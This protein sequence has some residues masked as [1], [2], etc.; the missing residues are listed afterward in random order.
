MAIL[1]P[2]QKLLFIMVPGT[3]CSVIGSELQRHLG[4]VW[5]P[6]KDLVENGR[7]VLRRKHNTV[8]Q[9]LRAGVL[10]EQDLQDLLIFATA[11]NPY[12]RFVTYYQRLVGGWADNYLD[13][14]ER[15]I[16]R[17]KEN[18]TEREYNVKLR[19]YARL[20]ERKERR[21]RLIKRVG[22]NT[23][24]KASLLRW[25]FADLRKSGSDVVRVEQAFPMLNRV[26]IAIRYER[27][28]DGLNEVLQLAGVSQRIDLP[29]KNATPGKRSYKEYYSASTRLVM[30][31]VLGRELEAFGYGYD[32][33]VSNENLIQLRP[34]T[35]PAALT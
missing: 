4:G 15:S 14:L 32:G 31:A 25:R 5:V 7:I 9:M 17:E 19:H 26:N 28:E 21:A 8:D 30:Q 29:H 22:F 1:C 11:R 12:D 6:E 27:L 13:W 2:Q 35:I 16:D 33:P 3:G 24:L 18:L 10:S 20:R 34:V 23:W